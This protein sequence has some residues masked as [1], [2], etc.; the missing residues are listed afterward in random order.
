M[1]IYASSKW[2]AISKN[3]HAS[4]ADPFDYHQYHTVVKRSWHPD[5]REV[6]PFIYEST[7][8]AAFKNKARSTTPMCSTMMLGLGT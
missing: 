2:Y 3:N 1:E 6:G 7:A 5:Y 8:Y 4:P